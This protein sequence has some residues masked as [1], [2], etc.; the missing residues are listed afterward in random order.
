MLKNGMHKIKMSPYK[1]RIPV[2]SII[3]MYNIATI[4]RLQ[5]LPTEK[6]FLA[7]P[8]DFGHIELATTWSLLLLTSIITSI[9]TEKAWEG[10]INFSVSICPSVLLIVAVIGQPQGPMAL[11][12]NL[13][14]YNL[15]HFS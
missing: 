11:K 1:L 3:S 7:R 15:A 5:N 12:Q 14:R 4:K 9:I 10:L 8:T 13:Y 2:I 6:N